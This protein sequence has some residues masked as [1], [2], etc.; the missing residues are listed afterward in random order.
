MSS[1]LDDSAYVEAISTINELLSAWVGEAKAAVELRSDLP[2]DVILYTIYAQTCD[3]T[4]DFLK[5]AESGPTTRS[6]S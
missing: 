3:P 4:L 2:D 1:L 6:S 5:M